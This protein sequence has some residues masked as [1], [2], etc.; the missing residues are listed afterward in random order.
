MSADR[1]YEDPQDH[2]CYFQGIVQRQPPFQI[3]APSKTICAA[4]A[5]LLATLLPLVAAGSTSSRAVAAGGAH[6]LALADDGVVWAWGFND[7]GQ[8]GDGS[9]QYSTA[10]IQVQGL[11]AIQA[12]SAGFTNSMALDRE[13]SVW[14]WGSNQFG[15]L[16]D[17]TT[18]SHARPEKIKGLDHI[19]AIALNAGRGMAI[20]ED[21]SLWLW[22]QDNGPTPTQ[23]PALNRVAGIAL[24]QSSAFTFTFDCVLWA[25][26]KN[27]FGQLGNDISPNQTKPARAN[28]SACLTGIAAS[29]HTIALSSNGEVWSWGYNRD[30][31]LGHG[32]NINSC[33]PTIIPVLSNIIAVSCDQHSLALQTDGSVWSW[34]VNDFGQ[35]G[36]GTTTSHNQPVKVEGLRAATGIAA[37][38]M[39]SVAT[40][41]DGSVWAWGLN[42]YGQLGDGSL[43]NRSVP[44][45]V[46]GFDGFGLLNLKQT[47]N[48][49]SKPGEQQEIPPV[50]FT[51]EP[52]T[53]AAPLTTTFRAII[54]DGP[55]PISVQWDFGDG[56]VANTITTRH[57]YQSPG[58]Y[59]ATLNVTYR[60]GLFRESMKQI[61]VKAAW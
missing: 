25:W 27:S 18:T 15:E 55:A 54:D 32:S 35:L 42:N 34:G 52:S 36:L 59:I 60:Q 1:H 21:G 61:H 23:L 30:G 58:S 46:S 47:V 10:P 3:S 39:F 2:T 51:V 28:I 53:G 19:N 38:A 22:G 14:A 11:P 6:A 13:G 24:G 49:S 48:N 9:L 50:S 37:G 43:E 57:T 8:L 16:G 41:A 12:I 17:G 45:Q 44:T 5:L 7:Q 20:R 4:L 31:Q 33:Q 29:N 56:E 26:G 40:K